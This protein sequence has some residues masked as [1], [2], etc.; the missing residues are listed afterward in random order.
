VKIFSISARVALALGVG[1]M[2]AANG[3]AIAQTVPDNGVPQTGLDIPE[4][5]QIFGKLDPNVRK[6]TAIVNG[7]VI[8]GTDVDQR[9]ALIVAANQYQL[10]DQEREQ[11]RLMVLRGLIDEV[12]QIQEAKTNDITVT[13]A[14]IDQA[15]ARVAAN[16][17]QSPQEF[18][19]Y[20]R[21]IGSSDR[22]VRKQ[23][24]GELAWQR[25]LRR[26][27]EPR[28]NVSD[29][30]VQAILDRMNRDKGTEEYH[31]YEIYKNASTNPQAVVA[32]MQQMMQ[33][34]KD[35]KQSFRYFAQTQS[36]ATTG[37]SGG[38][39]GWVRNSMLPAELGTAAAQ[40]QVGQLAGPIETPGGFSILYM[41]EK[42]QVLGT[43][44]LG[45]KLSLKQI[46]ITF[47]AGT[48]QEQASTRASE[49]AKA[50]QAINGCGA[51]NQAA[52]SLG[53][54]VVDNDS[55]T[56]RDLPPALQQMVLSM[57][58]GQATPPFGSPAEGVSVLVLCGRDDPKA[59]ILP[60]AEDLQYQME[61]DRVNKRAQKILRDLRR[62]AIIEYR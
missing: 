51:A 15:Y 53:A 9:M 56:A 62:D 38:D 55:L 2:M 44:P 33:E 26:N 48:T 41:A 61:Q 11:L 43:D 52:A 30:E 24:E 19:P 14:E 12:L 25:Y 46:K 47:P 39:L 36:E 50:T 31:L 27:V 7:V 13:P 5:L 21:S 8:T 17:K 34:M 60:K 22:S 1:A 45:A 20:L 49:F 29:E 35:G 32:G 37:P 28:V 23:I 54:E 3:A 10:N 6:P 40:M 16:F 59:A 4:N 18:G 42:R 57:Q 58:I